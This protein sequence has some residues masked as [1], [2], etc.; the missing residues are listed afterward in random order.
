MKRRAIYPGSFDP[1]TNGHI[2]IIQRAK[3][4]FDEVNVVVM[5]NPDKKTLFSVDE[6]ISFIQSLFADDSSIVAEG[7]EGLLVNYAQEKDIYT[8]IRGLRAV[9][10]FDYEFQMALTNRQLL[11]RMDTV[12]FMTDVSY[13]YLSSSLVQQVS[14]F[15]GEVKEFIPEIVLN[16]L[17]EKFSHE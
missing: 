12:F 2:D 3:G 14:K 7:Y 5:T 15:G 11:K 16:A 10:D 9:S 4:V 1:I 13:S 17:K 8:M 6:R